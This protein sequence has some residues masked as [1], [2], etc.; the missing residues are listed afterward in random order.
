[1]INYGNFYE[2]FEKKSFG[3]YLTDV[4]GKTMKMW[5]KYLNSLVKVRDQILKYLW[6]FMTIFAIYNILAIF[7]KH[8]INQLF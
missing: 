7:T 1:M 3:M 2:I 4:P 6:R 8:T 5:K